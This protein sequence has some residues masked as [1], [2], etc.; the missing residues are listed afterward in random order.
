MQVL[1]NTSSIFDWRAGQPVPEFPFRGDVI[2]AT[3]PGKTNMAMTIG[4]PDGTILTI[5]QFR[6]PGYAH[7]N[8]DYCHDFKSF[9][10][11]YL[12]NCNVTVF[13]IEA[14]ISK[15]GMNFHRSS[16]VLTEIR[17]NLIDL[18]YSMTGRKAFE[19]NNW[20]W[21]YAILPDG[22]RGQHEKGSATFLPEVYHAYGN[23]DVTDSICIYRYAVSKVGNPSY[24]IR[25]DRVEE[26]SHEYLIKLIP[27]DCILTRTSR[28]FVYNPDLS[29]EANLNYAV[30]RTTQRVYADIP[31]ELLSIED[32]YK[33]AML[34]KSYEEHPQV[35]VIAL[36]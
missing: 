29:I 6:A 34:F 22:M 3:D 12:A 14:A 18:S 20:S 31:I 5:L 1:V 25:P 2:V 30:N 16:M 36:R 35:E 15:E 26:T 27:R 24:T 19:V 13:A 10:T 7:D 8:S 33:Y 23:A 4:T 11:A 28:K 21:K 32:I 9:L 17:A